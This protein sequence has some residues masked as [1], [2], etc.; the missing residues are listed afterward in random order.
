MRPAAR[1]LRAL[2]AATTVLAVLPATGCVT[3]EVV[4]AIYNRQ[5]VEVILVEHR[6]GSKVIDRGFKHPTRISEQRL[7]NILGALEIRGREEQLAGIRY[8]F[9]HDHLP[10]AAAALAYGLGKAGPDQSVAVRM[11][12]KVRQTGIFDRKFITSFVA[13]VQEELL[14][15]HLSRVDWKVPERAQKTSMPL[16]RVDEHPMKFKMNVPKGMYAEGNYAV[17]VEWQSA[18]FQGALQ[19][20]AGEGKGERTILLEDDIP[21]ER[22]ASGI[23]GDM[24]AR[25]SAEQLRQLA[26]LEEARQRGTMTEGHYRRLRQKIL[27]EAMDK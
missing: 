7:S 1:P 23:P 19:R 27:D 14:F 26:D 20:V 15:I 11:T 21:A 12:S 9:E 10:R 8:V 22:P 13:Y 6:Q 3:R 18:E 5:R 24:L 4:D 16:P 17:S 2:L 25:L